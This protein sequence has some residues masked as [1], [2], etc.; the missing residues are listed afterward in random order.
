MLHPVLA[1]SV[2]E[3]FDQFGLHTEAFIA[4]LI[5]FIIIATIIGV[6]GI[7]PVMKQ[8]EERRKRIEEGEAMREQSEKELAEVKQQSERIL[9]EA[10]DSGKQEIDRARAS[11]AR[12]QADLTAKAGAE[13]QS[14]IANARS[15]A[16]LDTEREKQALR[17]D[18]ARL[19]ALT[20]A[21]VTGKVLSEADHRA[22]N[23]EAIS[24][25]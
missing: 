23:A 3:L 20:T 25:L 17:A 13:A 5:A 18:F 1:T 12:I 7:K 2:G 16:S 21:Q 14:I 8:L 10:R 24:K 11:A 22:I 9:D 6:F 4:H 15:Q 19:V